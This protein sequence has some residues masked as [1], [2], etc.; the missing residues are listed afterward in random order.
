MATL[1][2]CA[3]CLRDVSVDPVVLNCGHRFCGSCIG[4][5][6]QHDM[7]RCPTCRRPHELD[8]EVL[9]ERS[10]E[11]RRSYRS[12]RLGKT[13]G[14]KG[15]VGAIANPQVQSTK[16]KFATKPLP[17]TSSAKQ[18]LKEPVRARIMPLQNVRV[19]SFGHWV[20][21]PLC[22]SILAE[23]GAELV[24]I[25]PLGGLP[26]DLQ[27]NTVL[28]RDAKAR[29]RIDLKS[30]WGRRAIVLALIAKTDVLIE[31]FRPGV[32]ARLGLSKDVCLKVNPGL[33]FLSM[34][35][36][37]SSDTTPIGSEGEGPPLNAAQAWEAVILARSGVL[38]GAG[39]NRQLMG[40]EANYT[41]LPLAS[42]YGAILGAVGVAMALYS[43]DSS[44]HGT[45]L[46]VPL[47]SALL[48]SLVHNSLDVKGLAE[49]YYCLREQEL[50]RRSR[51]GEHEPALHKAQVSDLLDP[52]YSTYMCADG[53]PIYLVAPAHL[54]HQFRAIQ[55]VLGIE[56]PDAAREFGL[57]K[58]WS[59]RSEGL[60]GVQL[61][62]DVRSKLRA[63]FAAAFRTRSARDW[64]LDLAKAR[65]P[66]AAVNTVHEWA[67]QP[68]VQASGL[69]LP[70]SVELAASGICHVPGPIAWIHST[71]AVDAEPSSLAPE[72]ERNLSESHLQMM[73]GVKVVDLCNVIAGPTVSEVLARFGADVTKIDPV[74]PSYDPVIAARYGVIVNR[75]KRSALLDIK[76]NSGRDALHAILRDADLVTVNTPSQDLSKYGLAPEQL[77][78]VNPNIVLCQFDAYGAVHERGSRIE[79]VSY[80]DNLQAALGIMAYFGGTL[81]TPEEHMHVGTIDVVSG[82]AGAFSAVLGLLAQ[83]RQGCKRASLA[84]PLIARASLATVGQLLVLPWLATGRPLIGG[85]PEARGEHALYR[86]YC[87]QDGMWLF[88][89]A[90]SPCASKHK[91]AA[92]L[93]ILQG[94]VNP[95][96]TALDQINDAASMSSDGPVAHALAVCFAAA[97]AQTWI[98]H[99]TLAGITVSPLCSMGSLRL[100]QV[101]CAGS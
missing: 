66:V 83:K 98:A 5:C 2:G 65:V 73:Q 88:L 28:L 89:A 99:F 16:E 44:G 64:E 82:F 97:P 6:S 68:H 48:D 71:S 36:F 23:Q 78:E 4:T 19:L 80:D 56:A 43:R 63:E 69:L 10:A 75:G 35:G 92:M 58:S 70:P 53:R 67:T 74:V 60:G 50:D 13:S 8:P 100:A 52:F 3:V 12:W 85:G 24:Q 54:M 25:E 77:K 49:R 15:E 20:A 37:A 18:A 86:A 9:K 94:C 59:G 51:S 47:A 17:E 40:I 42:V 76:T 96:S 57:A 7:A 46:E 45:A 34:P 31:N 33:T 84:A 21:G 27:L 22:A 41:S 90:T 39:L 81:E 95:I 93:R 38:L 14:A 91:Q 61:D 79:D 11:Y 62:K 101:H 1:E 26:G 32:M 29:I 55:I 72:P 30:S 87:A